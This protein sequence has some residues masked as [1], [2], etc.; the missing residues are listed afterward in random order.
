M[1]ND[2]ATNTVDATDIT[3]IAYAA[4]QSGAGDLFDIA[5]PRVV[6]N[7]AED[8]GWTT[9]Y[10]DIHRPQATVEAMHLLKIVSKAAEQL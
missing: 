2:L 1:I 4:F 7:Q 3:S 8:G 9:G 5:F 10:G 6:K